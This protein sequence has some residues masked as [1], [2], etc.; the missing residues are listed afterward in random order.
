[1]TNCSY[2]KRNF[3]YLFSLLLPFTDIK[4]SVPTLAF[5]Q[6]KK[7]LNQIVLKCTYLKQKESHFLG[8][9][10][11]RRK[12]RRKEGRKA[13]KERGPATLSSVPSKEQAAS[14]EARG[15]WSWTFQS[16]RAGYFI[17]PFLTCPLCPEK[18][19]LKRKTALVYLLLP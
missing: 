10:K 5:L 17:L 3:S 19:C 14:P 6:L 8:T 18:G 13:G 1:M 11:E 2:I 9:W 4:R 15:V 7:R 16:Q 12:E